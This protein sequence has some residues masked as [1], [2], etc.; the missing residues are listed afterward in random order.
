MLF[1]FAPVLAGWHQHPPFSRLYT[2]FSAQDNF[3]LPSLITCCSFLKTIKAVP[4]LISN[5][6]S[7]IPV[8][9]TP[10]PIQVRVVI[11]REQQ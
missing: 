2:S 5:I 7:H 8:I 1:E 11:L 10:G 9:V 3:M 6:G 4:L